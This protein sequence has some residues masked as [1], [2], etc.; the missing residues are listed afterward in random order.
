MKKQVL[1]FSFFLCAC[2]LL[3]AQTKREKLLEERVGTISAGYI[4]TANA[5][6]S[7]V[8]YLIF[9]GFQNAKYQTISD[10]KSVAIMSVPAF[11]K[12]KQDLLS[13]YKLLD[14]G[15]KVNMNWSHA[16]YKL[17][18]YDFSKNIYVSESGGTGG[19]TSL[20]KKQLG[21]LLEVLSVIEYGKDVLLP[22]QP[23]EELLKK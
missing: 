10:F 21:K 14:K 17:D 4:K 12:F 3:T 9:L 19:Y 18:L 11:D 23:L 1:T 22:Q 7:E 2:S 16:D 6:N 13:A 8:S 20:T 5:E 15:E